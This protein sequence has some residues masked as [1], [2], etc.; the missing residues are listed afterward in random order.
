MSANGKTHNL[1][2]MHLLNNGVVFIWGFRNYIGYMYGNISTIYILA[3]QNH[4]CCE[5]DTC[6]VYS[7]SAYRAVEY[8]EKGFM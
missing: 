2:C 5:H 3:Y 1:I 6:N 4:K 8:M 7:S